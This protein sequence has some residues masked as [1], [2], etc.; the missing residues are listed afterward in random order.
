MVGLGVN[1]VG[2]LWCY[3]ANRR[4]DGVDLMKR[5]CCLSWPLGTR[6]LLLLF[7]VYSAYAL[8]GYLVV[9]EARF[10]RYTA[11]DVAIVHMLTAVYYLWIRSWLLKVS[12][13]RPM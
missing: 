7:G 6:L 11:W 9:G 3:A 4:G 13:V 2:I 5:V 12:G 8:V 1:I 10:D